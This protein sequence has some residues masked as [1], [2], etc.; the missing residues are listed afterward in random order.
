[1]TLP[2]LSHLTLHS[3]DVHALPNDLG[4]EER[5]ATPANGSPAKAARTVNDPDDAN[6]MM[7][8]YKCLPIGVDN[9]RDIPDDVLRKIV[10][11]ATRMEEISI[12]IEVIIEPQAK[13]NTVGMYN[14]PPCISIKFRFGKV[15][16][17]KRISLSR[18]WF[19]ATEDLL[20]KLELY[21][22]SASGINKVVIDAITGLTARSAT[23]FRL[24]AKFTNINENSYVNKNGIIDDGDTL[25]IEGRWYRPS[26]ISNAFDP[27]ITPM[28]QLLV[29]FKD[30]IMPSKMV[31]DVF[32]KFMPSFMIVESKLTLNTSAFDRNQATFESVG[33]YSLTYTKQAK[34]RRRRDLYKVL[35]E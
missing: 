33:I 13:L 4:N 19:M 3:I 6:I 28:Q 1:M 5:T 27:P 26:A 23:N 17:G 7:S 12:P 22:D 32:Q 14:L 34:H 31:Q 30:I 16:A 29:L 8:R 25:L 2:N 10:T 18:Q 35:N 20:S 15:M 21:R 9:A 11:L 24:T